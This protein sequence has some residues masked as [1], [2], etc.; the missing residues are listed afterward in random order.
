MPSNFISHIIVN[1]SYLNMMGLSYSMLVKKDHSFFK[2]KEIILLH[3][4]TFISFVM[5]S[6]Q[7]ESD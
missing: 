7:I 1:F 4:D 2:R 6:M 5:S 3:G